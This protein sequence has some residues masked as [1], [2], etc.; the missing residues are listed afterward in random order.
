MSAFWHWLGDNWEIVVAAALV[1]A[2]LV[3][4]VRKAW[5]HFRRFGHFLDDWTGEEERPGVPARPG[6][7][8]RLG[9]LESAT[10]ELKPNGGG[11]L[12]DAVNR[13]DERTEQLHQRLTAVERVVVPD[14]PQRPRRRRW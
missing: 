9:Q 13:I 6:V 5:P 4:S 10:R 8:D 14:A 3:R 7:M 2:F 12:K 1:L 11:S